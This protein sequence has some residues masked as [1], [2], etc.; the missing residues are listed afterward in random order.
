MK[1]V[2][3][4]KSHECALCHREIEHGRRALTWTCLPHRDYGMDGEVPMTAWV[5]IGC[6]DFYEYSSFNDPSEFLPGS[7]WDWNE[8]VY[9]LESGH[10][11]QLFELALE[12]RRTDCLALREV[13]LA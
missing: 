7:R 6:W 11:R 3:V 9:C 1:T 12:S 2:T 10:K 4:R 13:A 5:H 8:V